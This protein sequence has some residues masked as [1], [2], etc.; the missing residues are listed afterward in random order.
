MAEGDKL[1]KLFSIDFG[2]G[3]ISTSIE[4]VLDVSQVQGVGHKNVYTNGSSVVINSDR[5]IFNA[6]ADHAFLCGRSGVTITS[7]SSIHIDSDDDVYLAAGGELYLG[8]PLRGEKIPTSGPGVDAP[9]TKA[10][11]TIDSDYEP[12]VLGLKLANI[13]EDFLVIM[14][15]AVIRTPAGDGHMSVEMMYNLEMLQARLPEMLS[16]AVFVDGRSHDGPEKAPSPPETTQQET[17]T[18]A[19]S[20]GST[21]TGNTASTTGTTQQNTQAAIPSGP[22]VAAANAAN[23]AANQAAIQAASGATMSPALFAAAQNSLITTNNT[24][25]NPD[26]ALG[27]N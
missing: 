7:P 18:T 1:D 25:N 12:V 8:L 9:T 24:G 20:A 5:L 11:P 23:A 26:G 10:S 22:T 15:D 19:G 16:T 2:G 17:N 6:K 14:R 3:R 27:G 13:L 21:T 4:S